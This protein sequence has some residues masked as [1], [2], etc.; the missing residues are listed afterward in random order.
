MLYSCICHI[1]SIYHSDRCAFLQ[2]FNNYV[3]FT[4]LVTSEL[5]AAAIS[6][7]NAAGQYHGKAIIQ[8]R[9]YIQR[10]L[11]ARDTVLVKAS[12]GAALDVLVDQLVLAGRSSEA[13]A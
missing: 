2:Y 9:D 5:T 3:L 7:L 6:T 11:R 4:G 12:R 8:G 1:L 10:E 13:S